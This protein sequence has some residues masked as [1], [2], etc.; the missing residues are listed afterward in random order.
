[1]SRKVFVILLI[2]FSVNQFSF[3]QKIEP[4]RYVSVWKYNHFTGETVYNSEYREE[5]TILDS[6]HFKFGYRDDIVN[7]IGFGTYLQ[8]MGSLYLQFKDKPIDFDTSSFVIIDSTISINDTINIELKLTDGVGP[9]V[10]AFIAYWKGSEK[11]LSMPSNKDGVAYLKIPRQDL[12]GLLQ[13]S[14]IGYETVKFYL[15][16]VF[17][18]RIRIRMKIPFTL[19]PEGKILKYSIKDINDDGFYARGGIFSEWTFFK[20]EE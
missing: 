9:L 13:V 8:G 20:R 1:M 16:S 6:L 11:I 18:K 17:N 12:G 7:D 15:F 4:G 19:I 5:I 2:L 10:S 3:A 14:Y